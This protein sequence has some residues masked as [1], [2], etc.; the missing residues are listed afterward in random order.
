MDE[1]I[2]QQR[3]R[4]KPVSGKGFVLG[5]ASVVLCLALGQITVNFLIALTGVG[6]L[7]ILYY[8][9]AI[10]VMVRFMRRTVEGSAYTLKSETLVLQK[11][12]GDSTHSVI[13][14]PLS[15]IRAIRPV[16][17]GERLELYYRTVTVIDHAAATPPRMRLAFAA[18]LFSAWLARVIA[19]RLAQKVI[20]CVAVYEEEAGKLR[21]CVFRPDEHFREALAAELP[22]VCADDDRAWRGKLDTLYAKALYRAFPSLYPYVQPLFNEEEAAWAREEIVRQKQERR[23]KK[24][25]KDAEKRERREIRSGWVGGKKNGK[26]KKTRGQKDAAE[27]QDAE[28][29]MPEDGGQ[30]AR[31]RRQKQE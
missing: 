23:E 29:S 16:A 11:Q 17:A 8:L 31:R 22:D 18:S 5:V 27:Q 10:W 4:P 7:N 15:R 14:I 6:L 28:D 26:K 20:G 13:E 24:E 1:I 21:A 19:G 30:S 9:F 2:I 25:K 3:N 12:L